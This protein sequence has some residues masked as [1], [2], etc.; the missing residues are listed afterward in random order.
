MILIYK[1]KKLLVKKLLKEL[2]AYNVIVLMIEKFLT[3]N[4]LMKNEIMKDIIRIYISWSQL[5]SIENLWNS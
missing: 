4:K 5:S 1:K 2:Y 3:L